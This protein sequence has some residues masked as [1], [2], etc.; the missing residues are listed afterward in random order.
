VEGA[1]HNDLGRF[2]YNTTSAVYISICNLLS[3]PK[4]TKISKN[5]E[6]KLRFDNL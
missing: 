6:L 2:A 3:N 5:F 4:A 1:G